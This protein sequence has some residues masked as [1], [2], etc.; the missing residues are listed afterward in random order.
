MK[1]ELYK[2]KPTKGSQRVGSEEKWE[3]SISDPEKLS[4]PLVSRQRWWQATHRDGSGGRRDPAEQPR[5][6]MWW[7]KGKLRE[8]SFLRC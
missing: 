6:E 7:R 1:S 3:L 4:P 8:L 5:E 2:E